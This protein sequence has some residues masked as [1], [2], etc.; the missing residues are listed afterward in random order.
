M[1]TEPSNPEL[2]ASDTTD[3]DTAEVTLDA[4]GAMEG[5]LVNLKVGDPPSNG[6]YY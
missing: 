2:T 3:D 4:I 6:N 1:S 5:G